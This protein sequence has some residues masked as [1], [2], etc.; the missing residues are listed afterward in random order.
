MY[1]PPSQIETNL[2]SNGELVFKTTKEPYYGTYFSTSTG[3]FYKGSPNET[4]LLELIPL[5]VLAVQSA[6]LRESDKNFVQNNTVDS[7]PSSPDARFETFNSEV[8]SL[9]T[10][11]PIT[12]PIIDPPQ[13]YFYN[14]SSDD[15]AIGYSM[16]FFAKKTTQLIY[17]EISND[18]YNNFQDK[19]PKVAFNL[20]EV[21]PLVWY[22][23][24]PGELSLEESNLINVLEFEKKVNW[25]NFSKFLQ[26]YKE[27]K[28]FLY[29]KGNEFLYPNRTNY[30]GY[31]HVMD[32]GTVMTGKKHG[33][34]PE[35]KL[36]PFKNIT[37]T[38]TLDQNFSTPSTPSSL[39][40]GGGGGY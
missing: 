2:V 25:K 3:K 40:S 31:Y 29:T 1:F 34:G 32:N 22:L 36:I 38:T 39:S 13:F 28:D 5:S 4:V 20:Y 7:E 26:I 8:Y 10:K 19:S 18:T 17:I 6:P 11:A 15:L 30:I 35:I 24:P 23:T 16:R 33:D 14:P 9:L 21:Q 27:K 12:P 37:V